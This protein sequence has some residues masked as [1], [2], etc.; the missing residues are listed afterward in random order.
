METLT[1]GDNMMRLCTAVRFGWWPWTM[2]GLVLDIAGFLLLGLDL[3]RLQTERSELTRARNVLV[4]ELNEAT[5][6]FAEDQREFVNAIDKF[7]SGHG[8]VPLNAPDGPVH[9]MCLIQEMMKLSHRSL[10]R[11]IMA[12]FKTNIRH[13]GLAAAQERSSLP[14]TKLGIGLVVIGFMLQI[15]GAVPC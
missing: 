1:F 5:E 12:S 8:K 9:L 14:R 13:A 2:A 7:M 11:L 10:Q 4:D 6:Q 15:V 3:Y